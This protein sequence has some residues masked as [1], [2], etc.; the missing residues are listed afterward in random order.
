M[1]GNKSEIP[2]Q[3]YLKDQKFLINGTEGSEIS[4][5][6]YLKDQKFLINGTKDQ[7]FLIYICDV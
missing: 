4:D 7:K 3:H 5:Q 6:H 2:D 1:K